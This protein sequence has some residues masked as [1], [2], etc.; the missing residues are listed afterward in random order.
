MGHGQTAKNQDRRHRMWHLIRVFA[1]CL[2]N[3]VYNLNKTETLTQ[4]PQKRNYACSVDTER[5]I[6]SADNESCRQRGC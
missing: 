5:I 2:Q 4:H 3:V 6:S 1:V